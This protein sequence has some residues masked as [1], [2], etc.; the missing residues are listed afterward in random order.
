MPQV[1]RAPAARQACRSGRTST[2]S[3]ETGRAFGVV[4]DAV[5]DLAGQVKGPS[6]AITATVTRRG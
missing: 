5:K 2:A 4:A 3:C 1:W 6:K